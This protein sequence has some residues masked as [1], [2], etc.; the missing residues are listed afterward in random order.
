M[1]KKLKLNLG[2]PIGGIPPF[3]YNK[4][5]KIFIDEDLIK[6]NKIFCAAGTPNSI[7]EI[8]PKRLLQISEAT[9]IDVK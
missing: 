3:G 1:A 6:F 7:F 4:K 2:Y 9:I 5:V 8:E